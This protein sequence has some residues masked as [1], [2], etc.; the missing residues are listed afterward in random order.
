[1]ASCKRLGNGKTDDDFTL[2]IG[3]QLRIKESRLIQVCSGFDLSHVIADVFSVLSA[4]FFRYQATK[5][6]AQKRIAA[7][8]SG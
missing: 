7:E 2:F 1:M 6:A 5:Y 4:G 8:G 3:P